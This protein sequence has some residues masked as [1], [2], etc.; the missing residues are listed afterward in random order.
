MVK[1]YKIRK[2][3]H[4]E[5]FDYSDSGHVFFITICVVDKQVNFLNQ[6][7][8][9]IIVDELEFRRSTNRE[10]KLF[11]YCIMPDHLHIL[12]SLTEGYKKSLQTWVAA[13]KRYT[14]KAIFRT[15]KVKPLW[16]KNFYEH[17]VRKEESLIRIAEYIANNPV[18]KGLAPE[19]EKYEYSKVIDILPI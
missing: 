7:F 17:V 14:T 8:A 15:Y 16:Q 6:G 19:W 11:C 18:R 3:T 12:L 2:Q 9:K 13:F 5:G 10:I 4:I 1:P